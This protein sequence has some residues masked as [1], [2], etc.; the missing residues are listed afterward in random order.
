MKKGEKIRKELFEEEIELNKR[1]YE[2]KQE[3]RMR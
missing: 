3:N 1:L 2:L